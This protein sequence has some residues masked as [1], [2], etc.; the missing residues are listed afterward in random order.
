MKTKEE[1]HLGK[2]EKY[3]KLKRYAESTIDQYMCYVEK[4]I[5]EIDKY[6]SHITARDL[7]NY[8]KDYNYSSRSQQ[9]GVYS[10]L[11]LFAKHILEFELI[12]KIIPERPR[13]QKTL[14]RVI[15][16]YSLKEKILAVKNLKHRSILALG[17]GPG[18]RVSEVCN[19]MVE[20]IYFERKL[21]FVRNS[22]FNKDRIAPLSDG[23][24]EIL[25]EYIESYNP[26]EYLIEGQFGGRYSPSSCRKIYNSHIDK[27]TTFHNLRHSGATAMLENK[28]DLRVIQSILGHQSSKTTEIY[29]H[30]SNNI[31]Q[32]AKC[33]I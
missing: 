26:K 24:S 27:K 9:N 8:I 22:K 19:L 2:Y 31:I 7:S 12:D 30:V 18:L 5:E 17:F 13:K 4:A 10:S 16:Q 33:G 6:P 29:L 21:I 20:D 14:P 28:T 25:I 15:D 1:T 23:L 11:K 32:Q 3:L